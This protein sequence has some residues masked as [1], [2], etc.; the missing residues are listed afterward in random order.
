MYQ[1]NQLMLVWATVDFKD[2][3]DLPKSAKFLPLPD[4][5]T[6]SEAEL[7]A[8]DRLV[9]RDRSKF[10]AIPF[11]NGYQHE[12]APLLTALLQ[13][14]R[15]AKMWTD[16]GDFFTVVEA[17]DSFSNRDRVV[18]DIAL[19][20]ELDSTAWTQAGHIGVAVA[21]GIPADMV[22][23]ILEGDVDAL[24]AE[25]QELITFVCHA[26][27]G[28]MNSEIFDSMA[29]RMGRKGAVE[30][31]SYVAYKCAL[32]MILASAWQ[33]QGLIEEPAIAESLLAGHLKGTSDASEAKIM[34]KHVKGSMTE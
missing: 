4:R 16:F 12:V 24:S 3:T 19:L 34:T 14:P 31:M 25:D 33:A 10:E 21:E 6:L 17:R 22:K 30:Y 7:E 11:F 1:T 28:T 32:Q 2:K 15:L 29:G 26:A 8:M 18:A 23:A 27:R 9:E 5:S 13:S 20:A